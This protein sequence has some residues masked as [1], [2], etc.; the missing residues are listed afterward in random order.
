MFTPFLRNYEKNLKKF[1]DRNRQDLT[2]LLK[3]LWP[4]IKTQ[5]LGISTVDA[6]QLYDAEYRDDKRVVL[7]G[8]SGQDLTS[9]DAR[10]V[11]IAVNEYINNKYR[12]T[13]FVLLFTG[14]LLQI[15]GNIM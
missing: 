15:I 2:E 13:G 1:R 12:F 5:G 7:I 14:F 8:D 9:I 4:A 11:E 10:D 3:S 6:A